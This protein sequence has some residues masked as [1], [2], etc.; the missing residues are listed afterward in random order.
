M[1]ESLRPLIEKLEDSSQ[2]KIA[3]QWVPDKGYN[4]L[5]NEFS[6]NFSSTLTPWIWEE[7][8]QLQTTRGY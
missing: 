7:I 1:P 6:R 3:V 4:Y 8:E 5:N 2:S